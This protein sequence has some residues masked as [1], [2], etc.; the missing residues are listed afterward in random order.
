MKLTQHSTSHQD[1]EKR[2]CIP[3]VVK[4]S[5]RGIKEL[6]DCFQVSARLVQALYDTFLK[7]SRVK[8]LLFI[9]EESK[10]E[11]M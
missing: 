10:L 9:Y 5:T 6:R 1:V 7:L 3:T 11:C 8:S 4:L 2:L